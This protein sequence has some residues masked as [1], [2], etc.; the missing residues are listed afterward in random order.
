MPIPLTGSNDRSHVGA[1]PAEILD[2]GLVAAVTVGHLGR[3][4]SGIMIENER[5]RGGEVEVG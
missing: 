1:V 2:G 5:A 3:V 4:G